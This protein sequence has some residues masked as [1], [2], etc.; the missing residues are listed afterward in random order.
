MN[1]TKLIREI[2]ATYSKHGWQ[3]RRAL[4]RR[5]TCDEFDGQGRKFIEGHEDVPLRE[6]QIDALWFARSSAEGR[7]AWELRHIAPTPFALF[8]MFEADEDEEDREDV[9]REMEAQM[10]ERTGGAPEV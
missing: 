1:T 8:E 5:E 3:L 2:L 7:E 9:R 4:M 10:T 6:A